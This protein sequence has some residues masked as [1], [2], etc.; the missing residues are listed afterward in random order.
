MFKQ[1]LYFRLRPILTV[2]LLQMVATSFSEVRSQHKS[3]AQLIDARSG[4]YTQWLWTLQFHNNCFNRD[5][6]YGRCNIMANGFKKLWGYI[7]NFNFL[8]TYF[9]HKIWHNRNYVRSAALIFTPFA[10]IQKNIRENKN[11]ISTSAM[12]GIVV[13]IVSIIRYILQIHTNY[14][15]RE[16]LSILLR[17][18]KVK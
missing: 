9:Y 14:L 5:S 16:L 3:L 7:Y 10:N 2:F 12:Y 6:N 13:H 15:R 4:K 8:L 18:F 17:I 1:F 11:D